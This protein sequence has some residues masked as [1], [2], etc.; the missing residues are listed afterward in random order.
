MAS[1]ERGKKR[2]EEEKHIEFTKRTSTYFL[3]T[4]MR[5]LPHPDPE[6]NET[7]RES[8]MFHQ[9]QLNIAEERENTTVVGDEEYENTRLMGDENEDEEESEISEDHI[10]EEEV[11]NE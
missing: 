10:N 11:R 1:I 5:Q 4:A 9:E 3:E 7:L 6:K 8:A 2:K